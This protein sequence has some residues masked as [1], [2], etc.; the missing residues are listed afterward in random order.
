MPA[1]GWAWSLLWD[2]LVLVSTAD[3]LF[4]LT[5]IRDREPSFG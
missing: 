2:G 3:G 1:P 5:L 4:E